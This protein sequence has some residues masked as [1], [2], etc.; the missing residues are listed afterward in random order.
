VAD[1]EKL[2]QILEPHIPEKYFSEWKDDWYEI[3][4]A[5]AWIHDIGM[6][7]VRNDHG[8]KSAE[9][10]LNNSDP[11]FNF[12]AIDLIDRIKIAIL[13]IKHNRDWNA[14]VQ[15][16]KILLPNDAISQFT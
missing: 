1:I 11:R 10:V 14:V 15:K 13:C 16:M 8:E 3:T 5:S 7:D 2:V 4:L 12:N 6:I 9:F